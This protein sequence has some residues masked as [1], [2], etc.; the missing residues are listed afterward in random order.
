MLI[1]YGDKLLTR[2]WLVYNMPFV[3]AADIIKYELFN[4]QILEFQC[5]GDNGKVGYRRALKRV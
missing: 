2:E 3:I 5:I 4:N 1:L